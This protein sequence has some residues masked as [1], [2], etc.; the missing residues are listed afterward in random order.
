MRLP[1]KKAAQEALDKVRRDVTTLVYV[2]PAKRTLGEYLDKLVEGL[3]T[4]G[5]RPS[6]V[7][8]YRRRLLY[9]TPVLG[10]R[11]LDH[12]TANDLDRRY[13]NLL[14]SGL[15]QREGGLSPRSVRTCIPC[16]RRGLAMPCER[17]N[18]RN[19][20]PWPARPSARSTPWARDGV[21]DAQQLRQFLDLTANE[22][23]GPLFRVW[24]RPG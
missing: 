6:T 19:P 5:L 16:S 7:D 2:P 12:V 15:R 10:S 8:G 17:A 20:Q 14:A 1:T 13:S 24:R 11:R 21:V 3:P 22:P 4:S 18:S 9:V 23:L